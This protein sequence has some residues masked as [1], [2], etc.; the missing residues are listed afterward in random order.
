MLIPVYVVYGC[1]FLAIMAKLNI[2]NQ[3][4]MVHKAENIFYL[5]LYRESLLTT[6][7]LIIE[8]S[9]HD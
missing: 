8:T 5:T 6:I 7:I 9:L 3:D 4:G 2:C 1:C